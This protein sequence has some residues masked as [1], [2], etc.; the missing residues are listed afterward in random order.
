MSTCDL[1]TVDTD[2]LVY[3]GA[4]GALT[5]VSCNGDGPCTNFTSLTPF[6]E[7]TAGTTYTIRLGVWNAASVGTGDLNINYSSLVPVSNLVCTPDA[8]TGVQEVTVTWNED[9]FYDNVNIYLDAV[10][11]GNL[12]ASVAGGGAGS[13]GTFLY[14]PAAAGGHTLFVVAESGGAVAPTAQCSYFFAD[15]CPANDN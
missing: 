8:S 12:L 1:T 4:C 10:D 14:S 13:A 5:E 6:F 9:V 7:V 15:A 2:I 3:S 11:P